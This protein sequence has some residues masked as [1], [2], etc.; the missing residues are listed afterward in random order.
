MLHMREI[1]MYMVY[2]MITYEFTHMYTSWWESGAVF[3]ESS[4]MLRTLQMY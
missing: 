3:C 4:P 1:A 2:S